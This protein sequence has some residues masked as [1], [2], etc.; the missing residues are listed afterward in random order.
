MSTSSALT[1]GRGRSTTV[2]IGC[3]QTMLPSKA[4]RCRCTAT[5][6]RVMCWTL[7]ELPLARRLFGEVVEGLYRDDHNF[8]GHSWSVGGSSSWNTCIRAVLH[9]SML[10]GQRRLDKLLAIHLPS[11]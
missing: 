4:T 2:K 6:L 5:Q 10:P 1:L 11:N 9:Q 3:R 7:D 8:R